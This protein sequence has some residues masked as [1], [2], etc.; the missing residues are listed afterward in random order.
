MQ[1]LTISVSTQTRIHLRSFGTQTIDHSNIAINDTINPKPINTRDPLSLSPHA[2]ILTDIHATSHLPSPQPNTNVDIISS[3]L[4]ASNATSTTPRSP[5]PQ[6]NEFIIDS[7]PYILSGSEL[8][9]DLQPTQQVPNLQQ[10]IKTLTPDS[11]II[12]LNT[13]PQS[14][15]KLDPF[16][17]SQIP[18]NVV[19]NSPFIPKSH[20]TSQSNAHIPPSTQNATPLTSTSSP[21]ARKS[22]PGPTSS[23]P[24]NLFAYHTENRDTPPPTSRPL[25]ALQPQSVVQTHIHT[26]THTPNPKTAKTNIQNVA[27]KTN[28]HIKSLSSRANAKDQPPLTSTQVADRTKPVD[29]DSDSNMSI[30]I[31]SSYS[32]DESS[33]LLPTQK[34]NTRQNKA[35]ASPSPNKMSNAC[36]FSSILE[37][38]PSFSSQISAKASCAP[39]TNN[40]VSHTTAPKKRKTDNTLEIP[41]TQ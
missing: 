20:I 39:K 8:A 25:A 6:Q 26:H 16:S 18:R 15:Y 24:R 19:T 34:Y 30:E 11:M 21:K 40:I 4:S 35:Q 23:K 5:S 41:N 17:S 31:I 29:Y 13:Q 7:Q 14:I 12:D 27:P 3:P 10:L 1:L 38:S 36:S 2:P 22:K 28:T 33:D 32:S 9:Q 37:L